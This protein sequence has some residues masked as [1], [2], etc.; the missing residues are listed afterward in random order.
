MQY[1][2]GVTKAQGFTALMS[3]CNLTSCSPG[4]TD[5]EIMSPNDRPVTSKEEWELQVMVA[6]AAVIYL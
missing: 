5:L 3:Q 6:S 4:L 2:S 1:S